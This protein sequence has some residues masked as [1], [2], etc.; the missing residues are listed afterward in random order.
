MLQVVGVLAMEPPASTY[1]ESIRDEIVK[2]FRQ[3]RPLDPSRLVRGQFAGY[4]S[5]AGVAPDSQV[6]TYAALRLDIESWRWDGVPFFIRVGKCLAETVTEVVVQLK[7]PP[8]MKAIAPGQGNYV[9]LRLSPEVVIAFGARVKKPG[10]AMMSEPTELSLVHHP[11]ADEMS[12]YERLLGDAMD[13]DAT[14]FARQDAVEAAWK[15]VEPVLGNA[16]PIHEY[17]RGAWGPV[18]ADRLAVDVGGWA[19]PTCPAKSS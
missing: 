9:R 12:A 16:T 3:T 13:G 14:L 6:E 7:R 17:E 2:V 10:D 4:R 11:T 18:E 15:V 1:N 19:C 5:E 8:V